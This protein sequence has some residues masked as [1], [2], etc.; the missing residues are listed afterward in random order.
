MKPRIR[1]RI[2]SLTAGLVFAAILGCG[3]SGSDQGVLPVR[4][5][6]LVSDVTYVD[7]SGQKHQL[8]EHIGKVVLVDVWATWCPPC[9]RS[10]PEI[11][12]LQR[13]E[14]SDYVVLAIS[15]DRGGWEDVHP[16]LKS[17]S[18]MGL[19][20]VLPAGSGALGSFGAIP[21]IPTTLVIDRHGGLRERWSGYYEGRAEK[22][23]RA[24]LR[25]S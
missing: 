13:Q 16:F 22:A 19:E 11:A 5:R 25:E 14:G 8:A 4:D 12:A 7:A 24:A 6:K 21:G 1:T 10:L 18:Q 17:N 2:F 3:L 20:A 15:V 23:L 9:Q